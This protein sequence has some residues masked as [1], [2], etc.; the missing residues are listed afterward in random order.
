MNLRRSLFAAALAAVVALP[1]AAFAQRASTTTSAAAAPALAIGG[2]L[3]LEFG[4]LDSTG[5]GLRV[6]GVYPLQNL[7]PEV[8]MSLVGSVGFTRWS[9]SEDS[10]FGDVSV[11]WNVFKFVPAIRFGFAATPQ[12]SLYGDAGLG[13]YFGQANVEIF[14]QEESDS[15]VGALM[16]FAAGGLFEVSPRLSVGGELGLNPYFGDFDDS[17]VSL[18]A[19]LVYKL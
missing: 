17:T 13:L 16:R 7:T 11:S 3:G 5:F 14:G 18:F 12:L 2:G 15:S 9:E 6:D 10:P 8:T 4:A 19:T 1:A